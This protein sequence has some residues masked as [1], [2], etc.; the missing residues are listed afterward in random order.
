MQEKTG[1][2]MSNTRGEAVEVKSGVRGRGSME[3]IG[4]LHLRVVAIDLDLHCREISEM[5]EMP[6]NFHLE[7]TGGISEEGRRQRPLIRFPFVD[8]VG[9]EDEEGVIGISTGAEGW[10]IPRSDTTLR[11]GAGR[12]TETG[13]DKCGMTEIVNE[14]SRSTDGRTIFGGSGRNAKERI[15]SEESNLSVQTQEILQVDNKHQ[16]HLVQLR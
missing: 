15:V 7:M 6:G 11:P 10:L 13:R 16:S 5:H 1:R 12:A 2:E 14:N 8:E 4:G 3:E 9:H